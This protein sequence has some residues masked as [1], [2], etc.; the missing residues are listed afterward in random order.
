VRKPIA[1]DREEAVIAEACKRLQLLAKPVRPV[2]S[3]GI[4]SWSDAANDPRDIYEAAVEFVIALL[5]PPPKPT[6]P[7]QAKTYDSRA[8]QAADELLGAQASIVREVILPALRLGRP[9][10]RRGPR[11]VLGRDRIIAGVVIAIRQ[12]HGISL[13]RNPSSKHGRNA[14]AIVSEALSRLGDL[15]LCLSEARVRRIYKSV[16]EKRRPA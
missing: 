3:W 15:S 1:E 4:V 14:Y 7:A 10:K 6:D 5:D 13:D 9:P 2:C 16:Y 12:D 8:Q 11:S